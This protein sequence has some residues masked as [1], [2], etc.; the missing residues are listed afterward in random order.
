MCG[1]F[2]LKK[3]TDYNIQFC[4]VSLILYF[5]VLCTGNFGGDS[6]GSG[7]YNDFENYNSQQSNFGPMKGHF[8]GGGSGGSSSGRNSGPYGGGFFMKLN[9]RNVFKVLSVE[10][11]VFYCSGGYGGSSGGGG[12][13]GGRRY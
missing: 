4:P 13:Y 1:G 10:L 7:N 6:G 5:S 2:Y 9:V 3:K 11:T 12:G 8:G